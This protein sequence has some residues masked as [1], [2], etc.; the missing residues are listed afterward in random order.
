MIF[1]SGPSTL[2]TYKAIYCSKKEEFLTLSGNFK[3]LLSAME[4]DQSLKETLDY[5][6]HLT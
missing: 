2:V 5:M 1:K 4:L 6:A 3:G